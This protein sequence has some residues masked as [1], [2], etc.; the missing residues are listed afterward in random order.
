MTMDL[1][2]HLIDHNLWAAAERIG[3]TTGAPKPLRAENG[4]APGEVL[5][6]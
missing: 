5:G 1:Y 4:E 2:G 3:G 6:L